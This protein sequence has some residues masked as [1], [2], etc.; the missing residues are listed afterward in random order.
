MTDG[1]TCEYVLDSDDPDTWGAST[2]SKCYVS[3]SSLNDD[4]VWTCPHDAADGA[5]RCLFHLPVERKDD[6]RVA[7]ALLDTLDSL[8]D[9]GAES[10]SRAQ[11]IGARFGELTIAGAAIHLP[12]DRPIDMTHCRFRDT[13]SLIDS[14]FDADL[15]VTDATFEGGV[16]VADTIFERSIKANC[17]SFEGAT[18]EFTGSVFGAASFDGVSFA[19][20]ATFDGTRFE[21]AA[22]FAGME[23]KQ[24]GTF[25]FT[26][27]TADGPVNFDDARFT[28]AV[29]LS[30]TRFG[31]DVT[32]HEAGFWKA[33]SLDRFDASNVSVA[34]RMSFAAA[35][36][37]QPARFTDVDVA[38][39]ALFDGVHFDSRSDFG[40]A[41]FGGDVRF[42]DATFGHTT[43][44]SD[45][46]VD[47]DAD[48]SGVDW[49]ATD[50]LGN[51]VG[52]TMTGLTI[53]GDAVFSS[54][55]RDDDVVD[56]DEI[57]VSGELIRDT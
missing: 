52:H 39:T 25:E 4:G 51:P 10:S 48:F 1:G 41:S 34:G 15:D 45:A 50:A 27:V 17:A 54:L 6:H 2:D 30:N 49:E 13:V 19:G 22:S 53:R 16:E 55:D 35:M 9:D 26:N 47:D 32:F 23:S 21:G 3:R 43:D 5:D 57:D 20:G 56:F 44:W 7:S 29:D 18:A 14:R 40:G 42:G 28:K 12:A 8:G 46:V 36:F 33:N 38:G 11:F 24:K 31:A 37:V